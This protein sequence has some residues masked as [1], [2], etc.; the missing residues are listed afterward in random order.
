VSSELRSAV[1]DILSV[2]ILSPV[3]RVYFDQQEFGFLFSRHSKSSVSSELRSADFAIL[4]G[5]NRYPNRP[6][7]EGTT[8]RAT[9]TPSNYDPKKQWL[10]GPFIIWFKCASSRSCAF[11]PSEM[12]LPQLTTKSR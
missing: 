10:R 2:G 9:Y 12:A 8:N 5:M 1:L 6:K 4:S 7:P 3:C 11:V